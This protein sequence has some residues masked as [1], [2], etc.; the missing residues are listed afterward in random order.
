[1]Q[2]QRELGLAPVV[3]EV[4]SELSPAGPGGAHQAMGCIL[5]V[6]KAVLG[7]WA[8]RSTACP[9]HQKAS[10]K[11]AQMTGEFGEASLFLFVWEVCLHV[12]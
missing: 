5:C 6:E 9:C 11:G 7:S 8:V 2:T 1:M 12:S 3:Q 10:S 4:A